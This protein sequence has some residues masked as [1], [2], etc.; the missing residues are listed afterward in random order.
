MVGNNVKLYNTRK[1]ISNYTFAKSK[2]TEWRQT[3]RGTDKPGM[4]APS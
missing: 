2:G 3:D 1:T 4:M